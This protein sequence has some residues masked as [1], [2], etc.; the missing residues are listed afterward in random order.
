MSGL[1]WRPAL[2]RPARAGRP[3][4]PHERATAARFQAP[5]PGRKEGRAGA[6][7]SPPID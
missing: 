5:L 6:K 7:A 4:S 1:G 3:A 2:I